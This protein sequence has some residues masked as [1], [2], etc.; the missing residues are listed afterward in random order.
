MV[1][2]VALY[3]AMITTKS[4]LMMN[5]IIGCFGALSSIRVNIGYVYL[6]ELLPKGAQTP[7]TTA[8][9]IEDAVIYFI[10]T[11]YFW[12]IGKQTMWL[13]ITGLVWSCL[14]C[15]LV[16]WLPESPRFLVSTG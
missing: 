16:Y 9:C 1:C 7:V 12:K 14:S 4:L 10:A 8:W 6:M 2:Q 15:I 5:L 11:M 13:Q 3:I